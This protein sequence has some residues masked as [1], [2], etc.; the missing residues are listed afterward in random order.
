[1][2]H[3]F[4]FLKAKCFSSFNQLIRIWRLS[5]VYSLNVLDLL[6]HPECHHFLLFN[7]VDHLSVT[8]KLVLNHKKKLAELMLSKK[9]LTG[10][11]LP[12]VC[13]WYCDTELYWDLWFDPQSSLSRVD[14]DIPVSG[15]PQA[16]W[17]HLCF[18]NLHLKLLSVKVT[19]E[20]RERW[21]YD[22]GVAGGCGALGHQN[23]RRM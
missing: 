23:D 3:P 9:H 13:E 22:L 12:P 19:H 21:G 18:L 2:Q 7:L 8:F 1:M 6:A 16:K 14:I 5:L 4:R 17:C 20:R 15:R 10:V 11:F